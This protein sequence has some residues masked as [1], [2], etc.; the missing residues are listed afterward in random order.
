M[1]EDLSLFDKGRIYQELPIA[2]GASHTELKV[3]LL[4][5]QMLGE[6]T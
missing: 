2:A 4:A 6:D 5:V 3:T 1:L